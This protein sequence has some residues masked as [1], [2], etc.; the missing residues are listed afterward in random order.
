M[1]SAEV[2]LLCSVF[3]LITEVFFRASQT[4]RDRF[5]YRYTVACVLPA[6]TDIYARM[7]AKRN[8]PIRAYNGALESIGEHVAIWNGV[9][10]VYMVGLSTYG[11]SSPVLG[12][13]IVKGVVQ[14]GL[15]ILADFIS[16]LWLNVVEHKNVLTFAALRYSYWSCAIA[17]SVLWASY[18]ISDAFLSRSI[19]RYPGEHTAAWVP[20]RA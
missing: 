16:M 3:N 7:R 5:V 1:R 17:P 14:S 10:L 20:C 12:P 18:V 8:A 19:C 11:N 15:E 6:G 2:V 4:R 13:M 9:A